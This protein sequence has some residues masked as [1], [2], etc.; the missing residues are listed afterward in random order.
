MARVKFN[1]LVIFTNQLSA[2]ISAN[3]PL[4]RI[5]DGLSKES[6]SKHL[7]TVI[8]KIKHDVESGI[9]FGYAIAQHPKVFDAVYVNMVKAGM[10][11]GRL[12]RTLRQLTEY[13]EKTSE[14]KGKLKSAFAYPLF[15]IGFL[16]MV[17]FFMV[18]KILP[19]FEKLFA[20][21]GDR[22][23]P[24]PTRIMMTAGEFVSGN[25]HWIA[26]TVLGI[27]A[28]IIFILKTPRTRFLWDKYKLRI[29]LIGD[30]MKKAS[31][32]KFL[33][34]FA[35]LTQSEV[36]I[37]DSLALVSSTGYNK[38]LE[39]KINQAADMIERG[40][41]VAG[42]FMKTGFFPDIIIQMISSGEET[43][44]LGN[45]IESA[46]NFYDDQVE[47]AITSIV[48]LINPIVTVMVGGTIGLMMVAVFLPIFELGGAM[49]G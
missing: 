28:L 46:A 30:L 36:P 11:T 8:R 1:A 2:M 12:D 15:M 42:A 40:L 25:L 9:D 47:E 29:P 37:L 18:F 31:M 38:Y 7:L 44:K 45:L 17:F 14:T 32:G 35:V 10:A 20:T 34:A 33:R 39:F 13:M 6:L 16:T 21:F 49:R 48:A 19:A 4:V 41:S 27:V 26:L 43:G 23:L 22:P 3:L 5:L 24:L